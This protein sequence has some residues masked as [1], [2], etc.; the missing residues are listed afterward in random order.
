MRNSTRRTLLLGALAALTTAMP[1]L[2]QPG[3]GP[4]GGPGPGPSG[5]PGWGPGRM[6]GPRGGMGW[7]FNDPAGYLDALKTRLGITEAQ[8]AAWKTY[9]DV[10]LTHANEMRDQHRTMYEAMGTATWDERRAMMNRT[11]EARQKSFEVVQMAAGTLLGDLTP[12]Q[13]VEAAAI[14]PGLA[15]RGHRR[16]GM[17]GGPGPR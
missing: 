11:F 5:G 14:L 6:H 3:P 9:A 1:A 12:K 10:V 16:G 4:G 2:A 13:R 8:G 15:P 17:M 7:G